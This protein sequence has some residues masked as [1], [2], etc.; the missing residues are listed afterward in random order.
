MLIDDR[1]FDRA[2]GTGSGPSTLTP[3][4]V[5]DNVL[6]FTFEPTE[7]GQ[8]AKTDWRP[9]TALF[10]VEFDVQTVKENEPLETWIRPQGGGRIVVTGKIPANKSQLVRIYEVPDPAAFARALSD[11]GA[12]SAAASKSPPSS[13]QRHPDGKLPERDALRL[14]AQSRASSSRRR[15][16]RTP[17]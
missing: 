6:D 2:E 5:N 16:P 7:P 13:H 11:R 1:L 3:I 15:S 17:S 4:I 14:A 10:E 9:Q 8:P 12:A